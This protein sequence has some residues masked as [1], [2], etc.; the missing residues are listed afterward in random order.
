MKQVLIVEYD[1]KTSQF[2][3]IS[4]R[5]IFF[6]L[7]A[8]LSLFRVP[9]FILLEDSKSPTAMIKMPFTRL[10]YH[11]SVNRWVHSEGKVLDRAATLRAS[12][13]LI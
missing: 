6:K 7:F 2:N 1:R 9:C 8:R 12:I 3:A 13:G 10:I 4:S 5:Y 11:V